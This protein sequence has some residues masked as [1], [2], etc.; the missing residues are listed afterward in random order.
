MSKGIIT[1]PPNEHKKVYLK[2]K[3]L[4]N[5]GIL[6]RELI[7]IYENEIEKADFLL[8]IFRTEK[9]KR[10][11]FVY[12]VKSEANIP[13]AQESIDNARTFVS[14]IKSIIV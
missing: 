7:K 6:S 10:G 13:Y 3:K 9:T 8:K 1:T 14:A 5:D 4:A 12:N 11:T 2:L